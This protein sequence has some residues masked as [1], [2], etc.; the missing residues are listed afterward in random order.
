MRHPFREAETSVMRLTRHVGIL[1]GQ[2]Y[3]E[4]PGK[5]ASLPAIRIAFSCKTRD[6]V[7]HLGGRRGLVRQGDE[8]KG[9]CVSVQEGC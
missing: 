4:T 6:I 8:E 3:W 1:S 7:F 2:I 5:R 9:G